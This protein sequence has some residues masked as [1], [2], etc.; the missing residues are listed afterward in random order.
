MHEPAFHMGDMTFR[1]WCPVGGDAWCKGVIIYPPDEN[2]DGSAWML[3]YYAGGPDTYHEFAGHYHEV[4]VPLEVIA[5]IYRHEPLSPELIAALGSLRSYD[6]L[7]VD[8]AGIGY[9]VA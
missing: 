5:R 7:I 6:A 8:A 1:A 3:S 9:P 4:D 2:P